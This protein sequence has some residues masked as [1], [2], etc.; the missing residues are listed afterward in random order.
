MLWAP[1]EDDTITEI[2]PFLGTGQY[3]NDTAAQ[4]KFR[5][6]E[7]A[8]F[9]TDEDVAML[10]VTF[11]FAPIFWKKHIFN[12]ISICF[13]FRLQKNIVSRQNWIFKAN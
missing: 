12:E 9:L 2:Q 11:F 13:P 10:Q 3:W 8:E 4:I 7:E 5:M 1:Q 6:S